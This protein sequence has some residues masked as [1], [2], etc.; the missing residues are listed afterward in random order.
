MK[1][2]A[3]TSAS[4][5]DRSL[6]LKTPSLDPLCEFIDPLLHRSVNL[7]IG[8]APRGLCVQAAAQRPE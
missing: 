1:S 8:D 3:L 5:S 4:Y 7:P 6:S 2:V